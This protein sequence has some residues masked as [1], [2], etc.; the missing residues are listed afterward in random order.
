MKTNF[1][2]RDI[3]FKNL[4]E[5]F[6][7]IANNPNTN[8]MD[9]N[10]E[11]DQIIIKGKNF[12]TR[13]EAEKDSNFNNKIIKNI[14][15]KKENKLNPS[16]LNEINS[17]DKS[18]NLSITCQQM[19]FLQQR[20]ILNISKEGE[21]KIL[22]TSKNRFSNKNTKDFFNE[23]PDNSHEVAKKF[24]AFNIISQKK[25][26][27]ENKK[28]ED[29]KK[30]TKHNEK[31]K[32]DN[33]KNSSSFSIIENDFFIKNMLN[34]NNSNNEVKKFNN[35]N[36]CNKSENDNKNISFISNS[37]HHYQLMDID[38]NYNN[39]LPVKQNFNFFT[40]YN[41]G[42]K[43]ENLH[44][45]NEINFNQMIFGCF[46]YNYPNGKVNKDL[47]EKFYRRENSDIKKKRVKILSMISNPIIDECEDYDIKESF[48]KYHAVILEEK[49]HIFLC[50]E[51]K[52]NFPFKSNCEYIIEI[53]SQYNDIKNNFQSYVFLGTIKDC[54]S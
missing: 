7:D 47:M 51:L 40:D 12:S 19:K 8:H 48:N 41:N 5:D 50:D 35:N 4:I 33:K 10:D 45:K 22:N 30:R 18:K 9:F 44:N 34:K 2:G 52:K 38:T 43:I 37:Y 17:N 42:N 25:S 20:N 15:K 36:N 14:L 27:V 3:Y 24:S 1:D 31:I 49:K 26:K 11:E 28:P 21:I 39:N 54:N 16:N 46:N 29:K 23:T 32:H 13:K 53:I 6:P